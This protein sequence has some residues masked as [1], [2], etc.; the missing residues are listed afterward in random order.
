LRKNKSLGIFFT[1]MGYLVSGLLFIPFTIGA[2]GAYHPGALN[3]NSLV[4]LGTIMFV[5]VLI[6]LALAYSVWKGYRYAWVSAIVFAGFNIVLYLVTFASI[7]IALSN[8]PIISN[9]AVGPL[10]YAI[11]YGVVYMGTYLVVIVDIIL[12]IGLIYFL[13]RPKTK[14]YFWPLIS[15]TVA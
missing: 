3:S 7:N 10:G 14:E 6:P 2:F 1:C 5:L 8:G 9:S 12:N 15:T 11:A 13:T 4:Q